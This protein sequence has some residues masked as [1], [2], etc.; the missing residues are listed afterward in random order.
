M[1]K[2]NGYALHRV[3][4]P[5]KEIVIVGTAHISR[6]SVEQVRDVILEQR[7]E[8]VCVEL[9]EK[10][11]KALSQEKKWESKDL[12]ELIK[13]KQLA[14]LLANM[15]LGAYQKRLG[16]KLGIKPGSELA[17][18]VRVA[19]DLSIPVELCDRDVR[20]TLRRAWRAVSIFKKAYLLA[21]LAASLFDDTEISEERLRELKKSDVIT[22]L[23]EEIGESMP[24]LKRVLID[25]RDTYL[26]EKIKAA[27]GKRVVAVVGAGHVTGIM[28][29]LKQDRSHA[30]EEIGEIPPVSRAWKL[31]GWIVPCIIVASLVTIGFQKGTGVAGENVLYWILA[32]GICAALGA[33]LALAHPFTIASAFA[34]APVTSLTPVIG[35]G[36]VTAF[37]Q[38]MVRPPVVREFQTALND[39]GTFTGWWRNNLLKIFLAFLLPGFGSVIGT[40]LGGYRIV[41]NLF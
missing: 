12:I 11:F 24:E 36:Y 26:S 7:P 25:E 41:S 4:L 17:E 13:Q 10:R 9:D 5:G 27:P 2:K 3:N 31:A 30:M 19:R 8:C 28:K 34:A 40:W 32:N 1:E 15:I 23:M 35:A 37:V 29:S 38:A 18:A 21:S 33:V 14:T 39:M 16:D 6:E 22:E 20:V